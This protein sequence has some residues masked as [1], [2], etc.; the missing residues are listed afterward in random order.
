RIA[1]NAIPAALFLLFRKRF[2]FDSRISAFWAWMSLTALLL[3]PLLILS[4]SSTAID[5]VA[6]YWIPLQLVVLN[7]LPDVLGVP[8]KRNPLWVYAISSYSALI[9]IVWLLFAHHAHAWL[10]YRFYPWV[11]L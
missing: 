4:P 2:A 6:L 10:P 7:R 8:G 1:I 5:R 11:A 3:I 9:M